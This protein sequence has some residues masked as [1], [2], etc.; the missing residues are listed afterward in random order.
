MAFAPMQG[1]REEGTALAPAWKPGFPRAID[2][3]KTIPAIQNSVSGN[4][5]PVIVKI[6]DAKEAK[7]VGDTLNA[8]RPGQYI[9]AVMKGGDLRVLNAN[10]IVSDMTDRIRNAH[11]ATRL[12]DNYQGA[13]GVAARLKESGFMASVDKDGT[14]RALDVNGLAK[15]VSEAANRHATRTISDDTSTR[16]EAEAV[17]KAVNKQSDGRLFASAEGSKVNV[18]NVELVATQIYRS[19]NFGGGTIKDEINTK[20]EAQAV[21]KFFNQQYAGQF[22]ASVKEDGSFEVKS[23]AGMKRG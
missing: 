3:D 18:L 20:Q 17:A 22:S 4:A 10:A 13:V 8:G 12:I 9:T 15:S 6:G 1:K 16:Q 11:Y 23:L 19:R 14:V 21:T 7:R 5:K 2:L